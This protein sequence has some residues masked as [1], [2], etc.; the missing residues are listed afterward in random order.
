MKN[1]D[2]VR[3]RL[4]HHGVDYHR[5][6]RNIGLLVEYNSW[7]KIATVLYKGEVLRVRAEDVEKAG[8]KDFEN[9]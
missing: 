4:H 7:E 9:R 6:K 5:P 2:I 8:R 3:F 1:G